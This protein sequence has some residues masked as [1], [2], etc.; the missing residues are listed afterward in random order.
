MPSF[1]QGD[2]CSGFV[3]SISAPS[4]TGETQ[5]LNNTFERQCERKDSELKTYPVSKRYFAQTKVSQVSL[6]G[7]C[8]TGLSFFATTTTTR[9]DFARLYE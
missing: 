5:S 7:S 9:P 1:L 2:R 3:S 6:Y 4:S 8:T